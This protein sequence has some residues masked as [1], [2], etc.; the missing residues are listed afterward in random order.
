MAAGNGPASSPPGPAVHKER[1]QRRPTGAPPPLPHPFAVS[2]AAWLVLGAVVIARA[3]L[4]SQHT[5]WL[6]LDD[7]FSTWVLRWLAGMRTPWLTDVANGINGAGSGWGATV[8]G[9]SVVALT[10]AFRRWRHLLVFLGSV[11]FLEIA[12]TSI[13]FG[14]SR[15]RPYGVPIIG[16]W[17]GYSG[18][19]PPV[20][21]I[22]IFLMGAVYCLAVPGRA[23]SWTKAAVAAVVAVF[24]LARPP[25]LRHRPLDD[26]QRPGSPVRGPAALHRRAPGGLDNRRRG[27][28][29]REGQLLAGLR[30]RRAASG[31]RNPDCDLRHLGRPADPLRPARRA[32]VR[33]SA[34]PGAAV[35]RPP[36]LHI[37]RRLRHLPV[38]FRARH[39][40][41]AGRRRR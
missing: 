6:R 17:G 27:H 14:L 10:M 41:R 13:Y 34:E 21:V 32:P 19:S 9:L 18:V 1:R 15:P 35:L 3:F 33:A 28:R 7:R 2:T 29:Q 36:L 24:G 11:L 23:R 8:L 16:S 26:P 22:T 12:G 38:Q 39:I 5:P 25:R 4:V 31:H 20:A 37:P 40:P 30:S